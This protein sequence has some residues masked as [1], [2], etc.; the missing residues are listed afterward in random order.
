MTTEPVEKL[1]Y[2]AVIWRPVQTIRSEAPSGHFVFPLLTAGL[3][4]AVV[5]VLV[6]EWLGF[7]RLVAAALQLQ[8]I[9]AEGLLQVLQAQKLRVLSFQLAFQLAGE[10][11]ATLVGGTIT[12]LLLTAL[13]S[14]VFWQRI[15]TVCALAAC[16]VAV[17]KQGMLLALVLLQKDPNLIRLGNPLATN[18]AFF[19]RGASV[20]WNLL[21]ESLDLLKATEAALVI[22]GLRTLDPTAPLRRLVSA[23]VLPWVA[24]MVLRL[25]F[26]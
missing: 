1:P 16:F 10:V 8:S 19:F 25:Q 18:P 15:M 17:V 2:W 11:T 7:E 20:P 4:T 22:V 14:Q 13:G 26:A 24:W 23:A 21:L 5:Q 12:W 6:V 9:E 3:V